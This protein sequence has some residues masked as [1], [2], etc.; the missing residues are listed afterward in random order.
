VA[1]AVIHQDANATHCSMAL[2]RFEHLYPEMAAIT[3]ED[4][5][6]R[7]IGPAGQTL[8][9]RLEALEDELWDAAALASTPLLIFG[10]GLLLWRSRRR[11]TPVWTWVAE[12]V[13]VQP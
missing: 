12:T 13:R 6:E 1:L 3:D 5:S 10:A 11:L 4:A 8:E 9:N 2:S 7:V